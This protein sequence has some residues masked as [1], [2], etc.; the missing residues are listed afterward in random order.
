[1]YSRHAIAGLTICKLDQLPTAPPRREF[2]ICRDR[3]GHWVAVEVHGLLG[4]VFV[5][6]QAAERFALD[7]VNDAPHCVHIVTSG[8]ALTE[9]AVVAIF[10][11]VREL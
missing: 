8:P 7:E 10:L 5:S 1:L 3:P 9:E 4:G 6:R 2:T 11:K